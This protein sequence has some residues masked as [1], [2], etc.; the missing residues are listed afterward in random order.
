MALPDLGSATPAPISPSRI[1]VLWLV[2]IVAAS[3]ALCALYLP[4]WGAVAVD[5]GLIGA[6]FHVARRDAFLVSPQSIVTLRFGPSGL[7]FQYKN[8][9]W[10][11]GKEGAAL[12]SSFVSRWVSVVAVGT[13]DSP[14]RRYIV[15]LP[16]SLDHAA[17]RRLRI[18]LQWSRTGERSALVH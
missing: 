13:D 17:A 12:A 2:L 3:S 4:M 18:W 7:D 6:A 15:L 11:E 14:R 9:I 5:S 16:D 1:L 8:G 10:H